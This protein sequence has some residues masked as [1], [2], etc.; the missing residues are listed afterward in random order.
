MAKYKRYPTTTDIVAFIGDSDNALRE[1]DA[2]LFRYKNTSQKTPLFNYKSR[3][4]VTVAD[5]TAL[6][7]GMLGVNFTVSG[8]LYGLIE[9]ASTSNKEL[10]LNDLKEAFPAAS[11]IFSIDEK[12]P[13]NDFVDHEHKTPVLHNIPLVIELQIKVNNSILNACRFEDVR[14]LDSELAVDIKTGE[15]LMEIFTFMANLGAPKHMTLLDSTLKHGM[16][17]IVPGKSN[18]FPVFNVDYVGDSRIYN[19][20]HTEYDLRNLGENNNLNPE[21]SHY[22]NPYYNN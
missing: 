13:T 3:K 21:L 1:I 15:P 4:Y 16:M 19:T 10:F 6:V 22:F 9:L 5:G 2:S 11:E 18:N 12:E 7:T 14:F 17:P 8:Y 20:K